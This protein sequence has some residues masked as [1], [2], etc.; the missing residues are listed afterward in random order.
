MEPWQERGVDRIV[1]ATRCHGTWIECMIVPCTE[2]KPWNTDY[3]LIAL[4][5]SWQ[6]QGEIEYYFNHNTDYE[7]L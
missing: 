4:L 7:A 6:S 5:Q 3:Q 1:H 2:T